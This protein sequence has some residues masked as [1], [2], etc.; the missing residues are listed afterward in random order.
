MSEEKR[1][2]EVCDHWGLIPPEVVS[3]VV[4]K[5]SAK[6]VWCG[7]KAPY[8]IG[9]LHKRDEVAWTRQAA[10]DKYVTRKRSEIATAEERLKHKRKM[11][12]AVEALN[13]D[14]T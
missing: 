1:I 6:Q 5:E 13:T 9:N 7:Y 12:A 14:E 2:Y 11:L 10:I 3:A 4:I 8:P